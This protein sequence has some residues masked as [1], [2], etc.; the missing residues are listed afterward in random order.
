MPYYAMSETHDEIVPLNQD[1][2]ASCFIIVVLEYPRVDRVR[3]T[4]RATIAEM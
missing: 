1:G 3:V 2:V 4:A